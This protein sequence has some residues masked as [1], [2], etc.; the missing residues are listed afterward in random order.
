MLRIDVDKPSEGKAYSIPKDNPFI[1]KKNFLPEVWAYGLRNPW[2]Y[3][4]DRKGRLIVADVGQDKWE[5]ISIVE[6]GKNYGWNR[7]EGMHCHPPKS[8]C[9]REGFADPIF[10]YTRDDGVSITGGF[11]SLDYSVPE[12][13]GRYIF[14]DFVSGR[15]WAL[16]LPDNSSEKGKVYTLGKWPLTISTFG[17]DGKG[18]IYLADFTLGRIFRI[19]SQ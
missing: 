4:F 3:S 13:L 1:K 7:R 19:I 11:V 8:E 16:N 10:E 9:S 15:I 5:E 18:R 14:A 17:R 12:L 6:S 2:R